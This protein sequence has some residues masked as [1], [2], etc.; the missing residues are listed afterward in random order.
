MPTTSAPSSQ[1]EDLEKNENEP[2]T[3]CAGRFKPTADDDACFQL[4]NVYISQAHEYDKTLLEGWKKDMDGMLLFS[5]LYSASLTALIVESYKKLQLDPADLTTSLLTTIS[6]Q[7]A[8]SNGTTTTVGLL[9]TS[10]KPTTSSLICNMLWFLSLALALTCSLLATFV[11]QWTRDFLH[12]T[13]MRPSPVVQARVLAFSYFGLR[14]FGMHTFVDVIPILLH[15][16][17]FLF[18]AGLVAFLLPVNLPLTILMACVLFIF[19]LVYSALTLHP[20]LFLDTPYRT[21]LSDFLWRIA[22]G[23]AVRQHGLSDDDLSLT[24]AMVEKSLHRSPERD[25]RCM[26]F[27]MT[28]LTHDTELIPMFEAVSEALASSRA[29]GVRHEN[30][31]IIAPLLQSSVPEINIIS[32][33]RNFISGSSTPGESTTKALKS[34]LHALNLLARLVINLPME[35]I[36]TSRQYATFWFQRDLMAFLSSSPSLPQDYFISTIA[37]LR[38]S[39]VQGFRRCI[40]RMA[41]VLS[42]RKACTEQLREVKSIF[43][44]LSREDIDWTSEKFTHHFA[45]L[46]STLQNACMW[47]MTETDA[48]ALVQQAQE[49]IAQLMD[50]SRWKAALISV[51]SRFLSEATDVGLVPVEMDLTFTLIHSSIPTL[52]V[53]DQSLDIEE[54]EAQATYLLQSASIYP[55]SV[56]PQLFTLL[57]RLLFSTKR[58][59]HFP[60]AVESR[61]VLYK[62]LDNCTGGQRKLLVKSD[63]AYR[64][65]KCISLDLSSDCAGDLLATWCISGVNDVY[66]GMGFPRSTVSPRLLSFAKEIF[67]L[68]PM[69]STNFTQNFWWFGM[70]TD[71]EQILCEDI[72]D[73]L[74]YLPRGDDISNS[75]DISS[76]MGDIHALGQRLLPKTPVPECPLPCPLDVYQ[77]WVSDIQDYVLSMHLLIITKYIHIVSEG[78]SNNKVQD[79]W[80]GMVYLMQLH[81][82][83]IYETVQLQLANSV[84]KLVSLDPW[85]RRDKDSSQWDLFETIWNVSPHWCWV[86]DV[87]SA[88]ILAKAIQRHKDAPDFTGILYYEDVCLAR[89][90][91]VIRKAEAVEQ[92]EE[93][94]SKD[95]DKEEEEDESTDEDEDKE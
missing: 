85:T 77:R 58:A 94:E 71:T 6:L 9:D 80:D 74:E 29:S 47:G 37:M 17:L 70:L 32:R 46:D 54:D 64:L 11:Q 82:G 81:H 35:N 88:K 23:F 93:D 62:Y 19:M 86:N 57:I 95:E 53:F 14:R 44:N 31:G 56:P 60:G 1:L 34:C 7:L 4:W 2:D 84:W 3:N 52:E 48:A 28:L 36:E 69:A 67:R 65:E 40:E 26:E 18:F 15:I 25:R 59:L 8:S 33:I 13:T 76:F 79:D 12:K 24:E 63:S 78:A 75:L 20:L 5:A 50:M 30:F 72:S 92:E 91:T 89:C 61:L 42:S 22:N 16:S 66:R 27:T 90:M 87:E 10:F 39:R 83:Q 49:H 45:Q 38:T 68:I 21:P 73:K 55:E 51:L 41:E 43:A